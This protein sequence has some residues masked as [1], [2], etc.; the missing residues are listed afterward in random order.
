LVKVS[1]GLIFADERLIES[2]KR[3]AFIEAKVLL[4]MKNL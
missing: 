2:K 3:L 1:K 4:L